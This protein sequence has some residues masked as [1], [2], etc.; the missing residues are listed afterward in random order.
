M[1]KYLKLLRKYNA[2]ELKYE[3]LKESIK[4][5]CFNKLINKIGEPNEIKRFREENK[6]LRLKIKEL[7]Q[8]I[9]E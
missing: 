3:T 2:L 8:L 5:D 7:K 6:R 9:R 4:E 1:V